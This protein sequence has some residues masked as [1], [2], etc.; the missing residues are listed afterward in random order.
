MAAAR[1]L[2]DNGKDVYVS[3]ALRFLE[4]TLDSAG[5]V[6]IATRLRGLPADKRA[7]VAFARLREANI[8]PERLAAVY[9]AVCGLIEQDAGSHR[10]EDFRI[11]QTAKALHRLA[12]GYH[13]RWDFPLP[14]GATAP[15]VLHAYPPSSGR[16]LRVIGLAIE[17]ACELIEQHHLQAILS[18]KNEMFGPHPSSLPGWKP[19]WRLKLDAERAAARTRDTAR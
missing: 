15:I 19:E 5:E 2:T 4:A 3:H 11:V 12:S 8:K 6:E 14:S 10:V 9:L 7:R 17:R 13:K 16:V 18:L 1:W